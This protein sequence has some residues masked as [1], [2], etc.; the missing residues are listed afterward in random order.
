MRTPPWSRGHAADVLATSIDRGLEGIVGKSLTSRY[1][2]RE[3]R[4]WI[5]VKNVRH[6]EVVIAGWKPGEGNRANMIG[7]LLL[8]VYDTTGRLRYAGHVGARPSPRI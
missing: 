7:S 8:G 1:C 2:P 5:K 3:R 4:E 6:Q